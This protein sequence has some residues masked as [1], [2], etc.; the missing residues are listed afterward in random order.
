MDDAG[1]YGIEFRPFRGKNISRPVDPA[2]GPRVAPGIPE[3]KRSGHREAI[4]LG[5]N[6]LENAGPDA[7]RPQRRGWQ[8]YLGK[9]GMLDKGRVTCGAGE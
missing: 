6:G 2:A 4:V 5:A 7:T 9:G 8:A 1:G 3:G